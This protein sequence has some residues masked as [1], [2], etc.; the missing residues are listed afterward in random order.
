MSDYKKYPPVKFLEKVLKNEP[1]TALLY[2]TLWDMKDEDCRLI[3][4]KSNV[5]EEFSMTATMF[6]NMCHLIYDQGLLAIKER[7]GKFIIDF[8]KSS[9]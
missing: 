8:Q 2:I 4:D 3:V 6:K 5:R 7:S 1:K 9:L